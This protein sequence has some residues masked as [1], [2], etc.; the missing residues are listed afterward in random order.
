MANKKT[1]LFGDEVKSGSAD[2]ED[3]ES[4][5]KQSQGLGA[6][7]EKGN[8]YTGEVLSVGKE[9]V[10]VLIQ[11]QEGLVHRI[12]FAEAPAVSDKVEVYFV[13]KKDG[14]LE[15][16]LKASSKAL[17]ED[18][19]DAFDFE[20]PVEGR[21]TEVCNGG[22]RVQVM[23]HTAFCP[24][25]QMD[26]KHVSDTQSYVNRKLEFIITKYESK[27]RNIVVS[28]RRVL[29]QQKAESEGAFLEQAKPGDIVHGEVTRMEPFGAFVELPGQIE[30]LVH[31]SE[32]SWSR[33][34]HPS[35][36]LR[37]GQQVSAKILK[38]EEDDR[39]RLKIGLSMKQ[40][41]AD[42]WLDLISTVKV[43]DQLQAKVLK[44][45][46]FGIF[47]EIKP[48]IQAL[49]P[50]EALRESPDEKEILAKKSGDIIAVSIAHIERDSK[51]VSVR[52]AS[53]QGD[54]GSFSTDSGKS[55]GTLADAF[56][57]L[58]LKK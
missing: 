3:F 51:R 11:G 10:F 4:L 55:L 7:F 20:T 42:P 5:F 19:Q 15:F 8:K 47:V 38:I 39:G 9:S 28:R 43:G 56:K 18:L 31:I 36:M 6:S 32:I 46:R 26:L 30:A 22:W 16:T 13:R 27:G 12:E 49:L 29:E 40:V 58:N 44:H 23:N 17:A 45:E 25:S 33:I 2:P 57:S 21:V 34:G 52:L 53:E 50:K 1:D 35:E 37:V 54:W 24:V 48:G 41:E 14:M